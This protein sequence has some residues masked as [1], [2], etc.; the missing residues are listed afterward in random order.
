MCNKLSPSLS[1]RALI[2]GALA[3]QGQ[4]YQVLVTSKGVFRLNTHSGTVSG[5]GYQPEGY[6]TCGPWVE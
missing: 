2:A 1:V 5:C 6:V 4:Q 3:Y